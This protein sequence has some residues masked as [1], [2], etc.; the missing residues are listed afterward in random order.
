MSFY[1]E[2]WQP[3]YILADEYCKQIAIFG[4]VA[5]HSTRAILKI[6]LTEFLKRKYSLQMCL[7]GGIVSSNT[8]FERKKNI[9]THLGQTLYIIN[10]LRLKH[11]MLALS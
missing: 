1:R 7:Q 8:V 3:V 4:L 2:K 9:V 10:T 6:F 5:A 11:F